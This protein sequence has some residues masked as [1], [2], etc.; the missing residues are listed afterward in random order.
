MTNME[1]TTIMRIDIPN[2]KGVNDCAAWVALEGDVYV[3]SWAD[4]ID[5]WT[6]RYATLGGALSRLA[7]LADCGATGWRSTFRDATDAQWEHRWAGFS[8]GRR[9]NPEML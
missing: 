1:T 2:D 3:V 8:V 6:E 5:D 9:C 4:G 7:L